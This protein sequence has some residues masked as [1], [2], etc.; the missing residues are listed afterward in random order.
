[1]Y[2]TQPP[3]RLKTI[4]DVINEREE[5]ENHTGKQWKTPGTDCKMHVWVKGYAVSVNQF[6]AAIHR[7]DTHRADMTAKGEAWEHDDDHKVSQ[8]RAEVF[9]RLPANYTGCA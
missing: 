2:A 8:R 9:N 1:M 4:R 7:R 3:V 6:R 5:Y